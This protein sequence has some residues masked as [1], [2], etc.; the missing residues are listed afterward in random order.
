MLLERL[1]ERALWLSR[2]VVLIPIIASVVL[3][4]AAVYLGTADVLYLLGH[5][6]AYADLTQAAPSRTATRAA[7]L[8][9]IIRALDVYLLAAILVIFALGLYE[10]FIG[11]I[12]GAERAAVAPRLLLIRS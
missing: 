6:R 11:P 7:L 8:G 1:L 9:T 4:I 3:A 2:F 10:L 12:E 5:L